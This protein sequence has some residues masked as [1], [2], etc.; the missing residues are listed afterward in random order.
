MRDPLTVVDVSPETGE[1]LT[2]RPGMLANAILKGL[3]PQPVALVGFDLKGGVEFTPYTPRLSALA[4]T[5]GE[6]GRLLDDLVQVVT[7]RMTLCRT[8]GARNIWRLPDD[9]RPIPIVVLVDEAVPRPSPRG[10]PRAEMDQR[11]PRSR[12]PRSRPR[13][14]AGRRRAAIRP[15]EDRRLRTHHP[16]TGAVRR[17]VEGAQGTPDRRTPGPPGR[18]TTSSSHPASARRWNRTASAEAGAASGRRS[19][20]W[21]MPSAEPVLSE[22][23]GHER[24]EPSTY[25]RNEWRPGQLRT[26]VRPQRT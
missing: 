13:P 5:R 18:R 6:C 22:G 9:L 16:T 3:A 17:G 2:V 12:H 4:T 15:P 23:P 8:E 7:D 21:V 24:P 20:S 10:T 1:L 25:A 14:P 11:R 19:R 26:P